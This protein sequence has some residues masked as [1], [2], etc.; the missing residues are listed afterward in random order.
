M[1]EHVNSLKE[2]LC[3]WTLSSLEELLGQLQTHPT[4]SLGN[5]TEGPPPGNFVGH[6]WFAI[7]T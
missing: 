5:V 3:S 6:F 7:W 2:L 4:S 1:A